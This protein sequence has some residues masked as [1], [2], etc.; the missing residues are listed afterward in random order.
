[1]NTTANYLDQFLFYA[2]PYMAFFT[3]FVMTIQRYRSRRFTYSSLSSQFLEN[4]QHF[5]GL[6]PFHFGILVVLAGH[7]VAFL[8]P[9]WIL[10]W[11]SHP[12]RLYILEA[13]A[14][15]SGTPPLAAH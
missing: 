3:F 1:M 13:P 11:N 9:S 6:V 8:V 4:R 10:L 7:V 12:L 15:V 14:L 2:L 5:W